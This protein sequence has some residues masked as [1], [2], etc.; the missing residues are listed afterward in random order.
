MELKYGSEK[1][2]IP[3]VAVLIS[4]YNGE[5]YICEQIDSVLKQSYQNIKLYIRDDGSSDHTLE[6]LRKYE[7]EKKITLWAGKNLGFINSF[8][9]LLAI[10][11]DAD[12]YAW[13]DQDDIWKPEKIARAVEKLEENRV[14]E[15]VLYFSD[16]DY[17]DENMNFQRH[18]L[19]HKRGPSFANS[20]LDCISLGFCSVFNHRARKMMI[21]NL[22]NHCCGHDW[23]TYMV[24][25]AFGKV[26]YDRG[27][28]P[29]QYRRV[30]QSVSPGGKNF[31]ALQIWRFRKFFLNG[32]FS[33]IR[34]QHKEFRRIYGNKLSEKNKKIMKL[35]GRNG[36]S[37]LV[38]IKKA[39]CPVWFRQGLTEEMMVR[40]LFLL[41]EL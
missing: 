29:V 10:C 22:P 19:D 12:Y 41:G 28:R 37:F 24:C 35:F 11:G 15:P 14:V 33:K 30:G 3:R 38:A 4:T 1:M 21:E 40:I 20:L 25:A 5:K 13:C 32:Y 9:E 27:Y 23:W 17:Y 2:K 7:A 18:G 36:Y 8:F 26:I 34:E 31:W 16:Y 39:F 6:I